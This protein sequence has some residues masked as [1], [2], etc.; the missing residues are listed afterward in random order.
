MGF[1]FYC[2]SFVQISV[3]YEAFCGEMVGLVWLHLLE[4]LQSEFTLV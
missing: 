4:V 1:F 2:S 3:G